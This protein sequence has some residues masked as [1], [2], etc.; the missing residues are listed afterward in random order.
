MRWQLYP[1]IP[2]H[3]GFY[4]DYELSLEDLYWIQTQLEC[5]I[6]QLRTQEPHCKRRLEREH[7]GWFA[8][9]QMVIEDLITIRDAIIDCKVS[10]THHVV[11][12]N[13]NLHNSHLLYYRSKDSVLQY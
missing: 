7:A 13:W 4:C 3:E 11:L 9:C 1:F 5:K 10:P 12:R 6:A 2:E 8:G